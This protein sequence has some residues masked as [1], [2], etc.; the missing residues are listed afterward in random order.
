MIYQHEATHSVAM[1]TTELMLIWQVWSWSDI[2]FI[3]R[4]LRKPTL[5]LSCHDIFPSSECFVHRCRPVRNNLHA[6]VQVRI[7][8]CDCCST[9]FPSNSH[10]VSFTA[11]SKV[12]A[13]STEFK[14]VSSVLRA[15]GA[16]MMHWISSRRSRLPWRAGTMKPTT[17][18]PMLRGSA[19]SWI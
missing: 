14:L 16:S 7:V 6:S 13:I 17:P 1:P 10:S 8:A 3:R 5:A 18:A 12:R 2:A 9:A 19:I 11:W 4:C 15:F